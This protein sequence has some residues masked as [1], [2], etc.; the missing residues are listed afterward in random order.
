MKT[1]HRILVV[2][3]DR[4]TLFGLSVMLTKN[5]YDVLHAADGTMGLQIASREKPDLILLDL[6]L[7]AGDGFFVLESVRRNIH[8]LATPV[9][10]ISARDAAGNKER[11]LAAGAQEYIKKPVDISELLSS[12]KE[13]L[14]ENSVSPPA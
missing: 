10:V 1:N 6:G 8:L 5:G 13:I 2:E 7:P 3:D 4:D 12:I 14:D 11:A 9:F